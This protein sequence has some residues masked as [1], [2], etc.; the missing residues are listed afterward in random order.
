MY[1]TLNLGP[2]VFPT[3]GLVYLLGVWVA[4]SLIERAAQRLRLP[5]D[6]V[7]GTAVTGLV[8]GIVAARLFFVVEY[9]A[10]FQENLLGIIWPL[11]S[12]YNL[13]G[14]LLFGGAGAFF[15][16]RYRRLPFFATLD[17]LTPGLLAAFIA[18]SLADFLAG[19]GYGVLTTMPWGIPVFGVRRH[20]VQL[21]EIA[22][23][24]AALALW[25]RVTDRHTLPGQPFLLAFAL[26][27]AARLFLDAFRENAWLTANGYHIVQIIAL[28]SL[29]AC[30]TLLARLATPSTIHN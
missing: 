5:V 12:G 30:L 16:G 18:I 10:A 17:A 22:A 3:A 9:W 11:T 15:Y 25:W 6:A 1:P 27:S 29:L 23:G 26:Y 28:I 2:F 24:L 21:Y 14:G 20:P 4:L 19:P 7:Y 8:V 13:V